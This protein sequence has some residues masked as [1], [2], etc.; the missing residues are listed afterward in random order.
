MSVNTMLRLGGENLLMYSM[1]IGVST[2]RLAVT[3][4]SPSPV[5]ARQAITSWHN[6]LRAAAKLKKGS[7]FI[8]SVRIASSSRTGSVSWTAFPTAVCTAPVHAMRC[9]AVLRGGAHRDSSG[10]RSCGAGVGGD[11]RR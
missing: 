2:R 10:R 3:C 7:P 9:R 6:V 8:H 1:P 5:P 11:R 4:P